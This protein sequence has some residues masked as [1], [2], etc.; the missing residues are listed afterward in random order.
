MIEA[1]AP[2]HFQAT[3]VTGSRSDGTAFNSLLA[4]LAAQG[5]IVNNTTV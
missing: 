1:D 4:A 5:V 2:V 3:A